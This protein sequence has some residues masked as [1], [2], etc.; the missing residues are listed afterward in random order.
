VKTT[1]EYLLV[2]VGLMVLAGASWALSTMRLGEAGFPIAI[3]IAVAKA[4][5]VIAFYMHMRHEHGSIRLAFATVLVLVA[6]L[7]SITVTDAATRW[8][9]AMP[10]GSRSSPLP[11]PIGAQGSPSQNPD[12]HPRV[13]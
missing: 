4:G 8:G 10:P 3:A 13:R 11:P 6:L 5:L 1:T 7:M 9:L 12:A 2:W